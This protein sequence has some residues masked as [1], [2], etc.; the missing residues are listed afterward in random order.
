MSNKFKLSEAGKLTVLVSLALSYPVYAGGIVAGGDSAHQ[1]TISTAGNGAQVVNIV[2]PNQRGL[3][4]N[5]YNNYDVNQPGAVLNNSLKAGNSQLAGHLGAN[6]NLHG[7]NAK[8]I[9]NEV[10]SRNPSLLLGKQEVFGMVADYVLANPNGITCNGCGFINTSKNSLVVGNPMLKDGNLAGFNTMAN[11]QGLYVGNKGLVTNTALNLIAP[12]IDVRGPVAAGQAIQ[13]IAGQNKVD[14]NGNIIATNPN[15]VGNLDSYYLGSMKSDTINLVNTDMG[16]GINL[17][18]NIDAANKLSVDGKGQVQVEGADI[19]GGDINIAGGDLNIHGKVIATDNQWQDP[20]NYHNYRGAI[21]HEKTTHTERLEQTKLAGKNITLVG[22]GDNHITAA[23]IQG[24]DV[25][26]RGGNVTLDAQQLKNAESERNNRWFYS[27]FHNDSKHNE[28]TRQV[29]TEVKAKQGL[30]ISADSK[31]VNLE[32]ANL[33]AGQ[34]NISAKQ[35]VHLGAAV[36]QALQSHTMTRKNETSALLSGH[37]EQ[38]DKQQT[39][40]AAYLNA[41]QGVNLTAGR[42]IHT[43]GARV[44]AGGDLNISGE[45]T[46]NIGTGALTNHQLNENHYTAWGGIGGGADDK[47]QHDATHSVATDI[48]ADGKLVVSAD[49]GVNIKGSQLHAKQGGYVQARE[50][51]VSVDNATDTSSDTLYTRSGGA[52]NITGHSAYDAASEHQVSG[53]HVV[54]D[55]NL[56]LNG[57]KNIHIS[58]SDISAKQQ[59]GLE[60]NG[61]ITVT[62]GQHTT[63]KVNDTTSLHGTAHAEKVSDKQY[64]AGVGIEQTHH[65]QESQQ[66]EHKGASLNGGTVAINAGQTVAINGSSM[67]ASKDANINAANVSFGAVKDTLHQDTTDNSVKL[68]IDVTGGADKG[69]ISAGGSVTHSHDVMV[70]SDDQGSRTQIGGNLTINAENSLTQTGVNH[71]VGGDYQVNAEQVTTT[72]GQ[73]EQRQDGNKTT[74]G[75]KVTLGA[76]YSAT[77]RPL[78]DGAEKLIH[79]DVKGAIDT[80]KE[81]KL[82]LTEVQVGAAVNT[83]HESNGGVQSTVSASEIHAGNVTI[84]AKGQVRDQA[85]AYDAQDTVA[86]HSDTYRNEAANAHN[87]TYHNKVDVTVSGAVG[88]KTGVDVGLHGKADV[89]YEQA[90]T[91]DNLA[92]AGSLKGKQISIDAANTAMLQGTAVNGSDSV[93]IAAKQGVAMEQANSTH[94]KSSMDV[95]ANVGF[96][97][98]TTGDTRDMGGELGG[99]Y[100]DS[101]S[102]DSEAVTG[103]LSGSNVHI[104]SGADIR[105]QGVNVQADNLAMQAGGKLQLDGAT[106]S[107]S[108][109]SQHYGADIHAGKNRNSKTNEYG[110]SIGGGLELGH[111]TDS[112]TTVTG[113]QLTAK[114]NMALSAAGQGNDA[115]RIE[116]GQLQA[117]QANINAANGGVDIHAGVSTQQGNSWNVAGSVDTESSHTLNDDPFKGVDHSREGQGGVEF[118]YGQHNNRSHTLAGVQAD[119][120]TIQTKGDVAIAGGTVKADKLS[121]QIGGNLT[122]ASQKDLTD[123][124]SVSGKLSVPKISSNVNSVEAA[125]AKKAGAQAKADEPKPSLKDQ[126]MD[127]AKKFKDTDVSGAYERTY[128]DKVATSSA[129]QAGNAD[130]NV[131]GAMQVTGAQVDAQAGQIKSASVQQQDIQGVD[132]HR[133]INANVMDIAKGVMGLGGANQSNFQN[134][135]ETPV[136]VAT[137]TYGK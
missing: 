17:K 50:G 128:S 70:K 127:F 91:T 111:T 1:A 64:A 10:I 132:Q 123:S 73:H 130:L 28:Q 36:N 82:D 112:S 94:A 97:V 12:R 35:D 18:G 120:L 106:A 75:V 49:H 133:K 37:L 38:N 44:H 48:A 100:K 11:K 19:H 90:N 122:L 109:S 102:H 22:Y 81:T 126:A 115:I 131:A 58:G 2:T 79:G 116:G 5:T 76:D 34:M 3:S 101:A 99:H 136:A 92:T 39:Y 14:Y 114:G 113:G 67:T 26:V 95:T 25:T 33:S 87:D 42:D 89:H 45:R 118:D 105:A 72:A 124:T 77:T 66:V 29:Q 83:Q 61:N 56:V 103:S 32:A 96:D 125:E 21:D 55:T 69:E 85:T 119:N 51:Q 54:S 27:W 98:T 88:T 9:L 6:S 107:H 53:S 84:N 62:S 78:I 13:A 8:I 68:G 71:Q 47:K 86:I 121:G 65:H 110:G 43:A 52:F 74:V 134:T 46:V 15:P 129:I 104:Q 93:S 4:H 60:S 108:E 16:S 59:L 80:A 20:E 23:D 7:H 137:V 30:T 57:E 63:D 24:D 41:A 31:D 117:Q 40:V 135:H